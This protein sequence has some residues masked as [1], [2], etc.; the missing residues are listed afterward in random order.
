[1]SGPSRATIADRVLVALADH[2]LPSRESGP[3]CWKGTCPSCSSPS[4]TIREVEWND[5]RPRA[6]LDC[7]AGCDEQAVLAALSL[8][9]RDLHAA[10]TLRADERVRRG[11]R[12]LSIRRA[13]EIAAREVA[14]LWDQRIPLGKLT[15]LAGL[16]GQGKSLFTVDLAARVTRGE[17]DGHLLGEPATVVLITGED[18]PADT[19]K[20][21][22]MAADA[23]VDRVLLVD[24]ASED[25]AR[26]AL[27]LPQDAGLLADTIAQHSVRLVIV[28]PIVSL[29]DD[30]HDAHK[31]QKV[32]RAL[33]PLHEVAQRFACAVVLVLHPN[34][35]QTN[36]PS[37]KIGESYAFQAL[38]RSVLVLGPDPHDP[39]GERGSRKAL[40][41]SKSNLASGGTHAIGF[42]IASVEIEADNGKIATQRVQLT[43]ARDL[44]AR[45]LLG[46]QGESGRLDDAIEW[47]AGKLEDGARPAREIEQ[48]ARGAGYSVA[49]L[50]RA[51]RSLG[52][53]SERV[54]GIG[55]KGSWRW[56]LPAPLDDS[57]SPA[58][59]LRP[60][61]GLLGPLPVTTNGNRPEL[62]GAPS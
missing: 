11:G 50:R 7:T 53:V 51:K 34:K 25:G 32:R 22:L 28:D 12:K 29:L 9:E 49:T 40:A 54:G 47:L 17:L 5:G 37:V 20:P 23:D 33:A 15:V 62:T 56:G 39:E 44:E 57:A 60:V 43:G 59:L 14:W 13:S 58:V 45:D 27:V 3:G 24:L 35:T 2:G 38:G 19:I 36:D 52:V 41:V 30:A 18:D 42:E 46:V 55:G 6:R 48:A 8:S 61:D 10:K 1:M 31:N 21:R 4:L 26:S 16:A